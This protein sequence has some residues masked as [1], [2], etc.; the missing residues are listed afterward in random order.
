MNQKRALAVLLAITLVAATVTGNGI[1]VFAT[2]SAETE[3]TSGTADEVTE[4]LA[5]EETQVQVQETQVQ[6][7]PAEENRGR[8]SEN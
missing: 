3:G 6:E 2:E 7:T 4:A 1:P 5:Q 8:L